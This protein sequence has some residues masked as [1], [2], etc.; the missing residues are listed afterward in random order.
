[1]SRFASLSVPVGILRFA[2]N[3][4]HSELSH[5][6]LMFGGFFAKHQ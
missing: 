1:M 6:L 2:Q 5:Y 3:D 4:H